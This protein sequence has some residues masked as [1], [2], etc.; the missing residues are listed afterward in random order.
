MAPFVS[1]GAFG[2]DALTHYLQLAQE[3]KRQ[4]L[5]DQLNQQNQ[6]TAQADRQEGLRLQ[7]RGQDLNE[8]YRRDQLDAT[9][10]Q[11][12]DALAAVAPPMPGMV[13]SVPSQFALPM[14]T[15]A[16]LSGLT[17]SAPT[18]GGSAWQAARQKAQEE[19][20]RQ[21][22][23]AQDRADQAQQQRDFLAQQGDLTRQATR[24][25][26]QDARA[27]AEANRRDTVQTVTGPDGTEHFVT[28]RDGKMVPI[29]GVPAGYTLTAKAKPGD[30]VAA[31][32]ADR[33]EQ[34]APIVARFQDAA[35]SPLRAFTAGRSN[36][37]KSSD[38]QQ[39]D[40]AKANWIAAQLR[41]ESG[42]AIGRDEMVQA[43]QQYFPQPGDSAA[44]IS[45]KAALRETAQAAMR[46]TSGTPARP[47]VLSAL[48]PPGPTATA[49][50]AGVPADVA[51]E[52]AGTRQRLAAIKAGGPGEGGDLLVDNLT[53]PGMYEGAGM[54][55][56]GAGTVLALPAISAALGGA[57]STSAQTLAALLKARP[58]L[59]KLL[60][61][62]AAG[63]AGLGV[64]NRLLK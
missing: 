43:D 10:Q 20:D 36:L 44:V 5:L 61:K 54:A 56:A 60:V 38:M 41:K 53:N 31:G 28:F 16:D 21:R 46:R 13:G 35:A 8:A 55:A 50:T 30:A 25:N 47:G 11:R 24:Q 19:L 63:G 40:A 62:G 12:A 7:A 22:A 9:A 49:T 4:A 6:A 39:Y 27:A 32:F 18:A 51:T 48:M 29:E 34:A 45:Q 59:A 42:A 64:I 23:A 2:L 37:F 52:M 57:S 3:Q 33:M 15:P 17:T 14:D 26:A 58:E 1:P